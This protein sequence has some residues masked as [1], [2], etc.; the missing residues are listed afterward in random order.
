METKDNHDS[1]DTGSYI[2]VWEDLVSIKD[3]I[4]CLVISTVTSLGGYLIAPSDHPTKPLVYGLIGTVIG[5][6]ITSIIVKPKRNFRYV[7]KED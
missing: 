2:E 7:N 5:F 4:I 3:L 1:K 6:I